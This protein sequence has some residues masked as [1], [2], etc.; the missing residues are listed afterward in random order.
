MTP[1]EIIETWTAES[2]AAN[3]CIIEILESYIE[4]VDLVEQHAKLRNEN[5]LLTLTKSRRQDWEPI[6]QQAT[7]AKIKTQQ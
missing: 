5:I 3:D 1:K 6:L 2:N 7:A 4:F